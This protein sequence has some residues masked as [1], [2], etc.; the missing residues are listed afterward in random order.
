M[1]VEIIA[2][3]AGAHEGDIN[4]MKKIITNV[5]ETG[6]NI[7]KFQI[8]RADELVTIDHPKYQGFK[9]KEYSLSE[10]K[11]IG[12]YAKNLRLD[13]YTDVFDLESV[14][15]AM[16]IG[17]KK[18]KIHS[19][20]LSDPFMLEKVAKTGLPIILGI[21]GS[22][23]IGIV[24]AVTVL[25][26]HGCKHITL[27]TGFQSFPTKLEDSDLNSITYLKSKFNLPVG[28]ADHCDADTPMSQILPLLAVA[29]GADIIEKHIT[30]DRS[31]KG[32]D[33]YSSLNPN[34]FKLM[35][36]NIQQTLLTFKKNKSEDEEEYRTNM[37]KY[38]VARNNLKQGQII[39]KEDLA[40]K[41]TIKP[42]LLPKQL[43]LV[44]GLRSKEYIKK[45]E[46]ITKETC[47]R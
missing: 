17:T 42:G 32:T 47:I 44:I 26:K 2:E 35:I 43:G 4:L 29:K 40:F 21:G 37:K 34:E 15:I 20:N 39:T 12:D 36:A 6:N 46:L 38:I 33:Y 28:Y 25:N 19:T 23:E 22:K 10:W 13:I 41:R 9:Q 18:I 30:Y 1:T 31:V 7:V 3:I 16:N 5:R 14:D 8:F 45:D 24:E 11:E 27:M